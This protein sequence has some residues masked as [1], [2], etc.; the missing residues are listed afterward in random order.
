MNIQIPPRYI[1]PDGKKESVNSYETF[2]TY[3]A[4][5]PKNLTARELAELSGFTEDTCSNWISR[6]KYH[7]RRQ[8][9]IQQKQQ[10]EQQKKQSLIDIIGDTIEQQ[11]KLNTL[12]DNGFMMK[13]KNTMQQYSEDKHLQLEHLDVT[14]ETYKQL[15]IAQNIDKKRPLKTIETVKEYYNLQNE[16]VEQHEEQVVLEEAMEL[17]ENARFYNNLAAVETLQ[18]DMQDEEY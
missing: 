15:Q 14:S 6:N 4:N 2:Y 7:Q 3:Y 12:T 17:A 9:I 1:N 13:T 18:E 8:E 11:I 5:A 10:E 16:I